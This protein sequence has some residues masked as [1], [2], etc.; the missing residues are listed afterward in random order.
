M[1]NPIKN[2]LLVAATL[3]LLGLAPTTAA[4]LSMSQKGALQ[5]SQCSDCHLAFPAPLL[6]ARSWKAIMT[7]LDNHFGEDASLDEADRAAIEDYLT[8]NA[9]DTGGNTAWMMRGVKPDETI[10]RITEMPWWVRQHN[11]EV[12]QR[13]WTRAGTKSNCAACHRIN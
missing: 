8:A 7:T 4:A 10:L 3:P 5:K 1:R 6:P 11:H 9:A 2:L 12:S 13:S